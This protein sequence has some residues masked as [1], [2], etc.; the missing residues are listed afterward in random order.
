MDSYKV[1]SLIYPKHAH[2]NQ[3][4]VSDTSVPPV[5]FFQ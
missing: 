4:H 5:I 2:V 1:G 3:S